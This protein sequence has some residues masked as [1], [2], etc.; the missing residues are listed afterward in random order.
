MKSLADVLGVPNPVRPDEPLD[1][2]ADP[3]S[4][5]EFC[6]EIL[7]SREYRES[8][9]RRIVVDELPQAVELWM[10]NTA[11]GKPIER[12]E[13]TGKDGEPIIAE[14]RRIVVRA[15]LHELDDDV[16]HV[17]PFERKIH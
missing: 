4:A 14:I 6:R 17:V 8:V 1:Q 15:A 11:H 13:H 2:I 5:E 10:L 3:S 16:S 9:M 12:V 7:N